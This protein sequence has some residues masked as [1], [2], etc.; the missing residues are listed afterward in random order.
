VTDA[1]AAVANEKRR[2]QQQQQPGRLHAARR[3]WIGIGMQTTTRCHAR[4]QTG[5][6]M[7]QKLENARE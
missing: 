4:R 5:E 3:R 7:N 2:Q 1:T 6:P